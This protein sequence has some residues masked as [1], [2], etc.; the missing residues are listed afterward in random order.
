MVKSIGIEYYR[1][2]KAV[3]IK[4][5]T[6][7]YTEAIFDNTV[8]NLSNPFNPPRDVFFEDS[9]DEESEMLHLI[10]LYTDD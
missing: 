3:K 1:Y 2:Q 10:F 7:I 9:M 6:A 8:E 5:G 4:K